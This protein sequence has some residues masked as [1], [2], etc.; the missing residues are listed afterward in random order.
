MAS[1]ILWNTLSAESLVKSET[2]IALKC[3]RS[4][5]TFLAVVWYPNKTI[6]FLLSML[7]IAM[8][9]DTLFVE[10]SSEPDHLKNVII[11]D[12]DSDDKQ[13]HDVYLLEANKIYL[14]SSKLDL[15][16]SLNITGETPVLVLINTFALAWADSTFLFFLS[17]CKN[18]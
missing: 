10:W 7:S 3:S 18:L 1:C 17:F 11:D 16:G 4:I 12:R 8:T 13:M 9:Q 15:Y 14:Q 6:P 2:W 5:L